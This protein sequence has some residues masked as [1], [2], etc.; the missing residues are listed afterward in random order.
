M[1]G[2]AVIGFATTAAG[3]LLTNWRAALPILAVLALAAWGGWQYLGRLQAEEAL[4]TQKLQI[5]LDANATWLE[6]E[7]KRRAFEANVME[8][9]AKLT[10]EVEAIH[11]SNQQFR[12]KVNANANSGRALDSNELAALRLLVR[13][14]GGDKAGGGA[15]RPADAP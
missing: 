10:A 1:G 11:A 15:V 13:R 9:L 8:G 7:D 3:W 4:A 2:G 12:E 14:A 6:L 5:A